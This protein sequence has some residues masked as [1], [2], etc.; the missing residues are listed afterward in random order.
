M[1]RQT[2]SLTSM[3][4]I[5]SS[6][7]FSFS[8]AII[9]TSVN[10]T[11]VY[12]SVHGESLWSQNNFRSNLAP[13]PLDRE[14]STNLIDIRGVGDSG[15]AL[16]YRQPPLPESNLGDGLP[17]N[18]GVRLDN[19]DPT[20]KSYR[21][22]LS[23]LNWESVVGS[24]CNGFRGVP[25]K[26]SF[27]FVSHPN[28]ILTAYERGFNLISLANNHSWDCPRGENG[29]DG[30]LM[31]ASY[32][33][34]LTRSLNA[35]WL[36]HGVGKPPGKN[37]AVVK[38][39]TIKGR[40]VRVAFASLYLGGAC[41]NITCISDQG[42][43]LR[44]LRDASADIRILSLH[45][46]NNQTQQELVNL[47]HTFIR[48]YNGDIVFGHGPHQW[49]PVTIVDKPSGT[50]GVIFESLGNFIHPNLRPRGQD[51]IG[52][53]LMDANTFEIKQI[54]A[55]PLR[56]TSGIVSFN[57]SPNP[58]HIPSKN[59]TWRPINDSQ[60]AKEISPH[61]QGVYVNL[62]TN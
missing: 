9:H 38:N 5:I 21:G 17:A 62:P 10:Q 13:I 53:V 25:S 37:L 47:G 12:F 56:V 60:W 30:A 44:S 58:R 16:T 15:M 24:R 54:Q 61:I 18:F 11:Q 49:H 36:W 42:A 2:K 34:N 3:L 29:L 41:H 7:F 55:I 23:F 46:W 35:R 33:I 59:F 26:S 48:Q 40:N 32:M 51:M 28:N 22:D 4:K 52:R 57:N 8:L 14:K 45:S 19:F 31:S 1:P 20:G 43:I 6:L 27:T 50:Q 39:M